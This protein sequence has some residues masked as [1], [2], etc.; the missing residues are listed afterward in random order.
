MDNK[1]IETLQKLQKNL[2]KEESAAVENVRIDDPV[3]AI[4]ESLS[5]F[6]RHSFKCVEENRAFEK[7]LQD[8]IQTRLPEANFS[9]LV[10]LLEVTQ[11]GNA[12]DTANLIN[13]FAQ[14]AVAR[15]QAAGSADTSVSQQVYNSA[16][17][18]ILQ[19][20][21][22]LNQLLEKAAQVTKEEED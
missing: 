16:S 6:V 12:V 18:E 21:T 17:K 15:H 22:V 1:S 7:T 10:K 9:Q 11:A 19:G 13:P 20:L 2:S 3:D 8:T 4:E 14:A 5:S